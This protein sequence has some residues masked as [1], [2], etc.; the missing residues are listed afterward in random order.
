MNIS[1]HDFL[2]LWFHNIESM[3]LAETMY[4]YTVAMT[5]AVAVTMQ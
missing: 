4:I 5:G 2:S 3:G 1:E